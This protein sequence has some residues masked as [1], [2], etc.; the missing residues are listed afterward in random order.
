MSSSPTGPEMFSGRAECTT[1]HIS[2]RFYLADFPSC[3][4]IK[5]NSRP[6]LDFGFSALKLSQVQ[7]LNHLQT[8]QQFLCLPFA[9]FAWSLPAHVS[10]LSCILLLLRP[11]LQMESRSDG[12]FWLSCVSVPPS[13][14]F[15]RMRKSHHGSQP[16]PSNGTVHFL[17]PLP[18]FRSCSLFCKGALHTLHPQ[19]FKMLLS[20]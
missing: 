6:N 12:D 2:S 16:R 19:L 10:K 15:C 20:V 7:P 11:L 17:S 18:P 9:Q 3:I 14:P 8:V 1:C 4:L 13:S 5:L